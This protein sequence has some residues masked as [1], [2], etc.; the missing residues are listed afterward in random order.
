[1]GLGPDAGWFSSDHPLQYTH[2]CTNT[3]AHTHPLMHTHTPAHSQTHTRA[4]TT[5]AHEHVCTHICMCRYMCV[6]TF[7]HTCIHMLTH[8]CTCVRSQICTLTGVH[9]HTQPPQNSAVRGLLA[10]RGLGPGSIDLSLAQPSRGA[11]KAHLVAL[12]KCSLISS[13]Q[14]DKVHAEDE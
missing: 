12:K 14:R 8:K 1:M 7:M 9:T 11:G 5:D 2:A 13:L 6:H 10:R 4:L 3:H